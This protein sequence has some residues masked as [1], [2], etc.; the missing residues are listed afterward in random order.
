M[1]RFI[2]EALFIGLKEGAKIG[3]CAFLLCSFFRG[4]GLDRLKRPMFAAFAAVFAASFAVMTLPVT[5][6]G[7]DIV[8]R[9]VGYVFGVLYVISLGALFH[10]SGTDMLGPLRLLGRSQAAT[11]FLAFLCTLLYFIP[12]MAGASLYT[13]DLVAMAG[14]G[15]PVF[16]AAAA[17]FVGMLMTGY[18]FSR[19]V[20]V[21]IS[22]AF[23]MPQLLLFLAMVKLLA[24]GVRGFTEL[25]LIPSVQAGLMKLIHDV[26]H[27]SFVLFLVPDHM[28]LSTTAWNFIGT[29]FG[30]TA[31]LWLSLIILVLPLLLFI[32]KHFTASID[33]PPGVTVPAGRRTFIRAVR[34][35]RVLRSLPVFLFLAVITATWFHQSGDAAA[36]LYV[37][38][39][40]PVTP[41]QGTVVLPLQAPAED[42]RDGA[43]HKFSLLL[44]GRTVRLL[45]MKKPDGTLAVC[46]DACEICQPDGYGQASG[47]VVC[48]YCGTPI[49][50]E[51]VGEQGGC[52]PI[53][54]AS[55]V[56][57][58]EIRVTVAEVR[59]QWAMVNSAAAREGTVR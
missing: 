51:T 8:V 6:A 38:D 59:K 57:E 13:A 11:G 14:S 34:D 29:A 1:S 35:L 49:P 2:L 9:M 3:L 40:K 22:R 7:R 17:G 33:I 44:D 50:F 47:H 43:I 27:Q 18:A 46:L 30:Q 4:R 24:G 15:F 20:I 21:D 56:T 16:T 37:P 45:I 28:I 12:D 32:R 23:G 42:L 39:P 52:N 36:R 19:R 55:L 10:E 31:G 41:E 53:P 58:N 48:I 25:S 26:V 5:A 54:L